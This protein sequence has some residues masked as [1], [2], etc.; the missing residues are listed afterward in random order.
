MGVG[1]LLL[2]AMFVVVC[3]QIFSRFVIQS[4]IP[5][6]E[7]VGRYLFVWASFLGAAVLV[8]RGEHFSIDFIAQALPPRGRRVLRLGVTILVVGFALV[9]VIYGYRVSR[10]LLSASSPILQLSLGIVYGIIPVSG[11]YML[12]HGLMGLTCLIRGEEPEGGV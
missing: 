4:P 2:A 5:W 9:M 8:G 6:T 7:E 3:L 12:L 11:L 1:I 10:R